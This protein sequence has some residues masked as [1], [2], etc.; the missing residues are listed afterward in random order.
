MLNSVI[1]KELLTSKFRVAS[2][3]KKRIDVKNFQILFS[4]LQVLDPSLVARSEL[5]TPNIQTHL[6]TTKKPFDTQDINP[7]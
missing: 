7:R 6:K 2:G 5:N 1:T 4:Q 3:G